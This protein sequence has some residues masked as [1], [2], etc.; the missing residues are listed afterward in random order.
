[1]NAPKVNEDAHRLA[2]NEHQRQARTR[3]CNLRSKNVDRR[4]AQKLYDAI[5]RLRATISVY[6]LSDA[7]L[8]GDRHI[9]RNVTFSMKKAEEA[10][11][12]AKEN[13]F[14]TAKPLKQKS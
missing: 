13:N 9:R 8:D 11:Q 4:I 6:G 1:M 3:L 2:R 14:H 7:A 10:M 12:L 5:V